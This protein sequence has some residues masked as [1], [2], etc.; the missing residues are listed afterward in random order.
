MCTMRA[1]HLRKCESSMQCP[2]WRTLLEH[3]PSRPYLSCTLPCSLQAHGPGWYVILVRII[4]NE[5]VFIH[6]KL[7]SKTIPLPTPYPNAW[8]SFQCQMLGSESPF[9]PPNQ[10]NLDNFEPKGYF[11][12]F[13]ATYLL[14]L[15][16]D[17]CQ[18]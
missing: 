15:V 16:K 10:E 9:P 8:S 5:G 2:V 4:S 18:P 6:L 3:W 1:F 12:A 11:Y 14:Q 17:I 13:Y 7:C